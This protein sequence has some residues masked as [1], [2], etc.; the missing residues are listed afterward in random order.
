M[1]AT[2][3]TMEIVFYILLANEIKSSTV[4]Y[5]T[6]VTLSLELILI[7]LYLFLGIFIS[8]SDRKP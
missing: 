3:V 2:Y 7:P 4:N 6:I 8:V 1:G 5:F